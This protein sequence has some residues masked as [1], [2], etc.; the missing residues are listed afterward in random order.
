[1]DKQIIYVVVKKTT[2]HP[3]LKSITAAALTMIFVDLVKK[4]ARL[5]SENIKLKK[6]NAELKEG[7]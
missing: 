4:N 5:E 6:E 1:M 3:V 7:D 2:S